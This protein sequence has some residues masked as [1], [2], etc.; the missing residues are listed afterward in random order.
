MPHFKYHGDPN[1]RTHKLLAS[2]I[3]SGGN[4]GPSGLLSSKGAFKGYVL[5]AGG[6]LGREG[7]G[8]TYKAQEC[9]GL[10]LVR[11]IYFLTLPGHLNFTPMPLKI[12]PKYLC[13]LQECPSHSSMK[14]IN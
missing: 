14:G 5:K 11:K 9:A 6:S 1:H 2:Y 10:S 13:K 7:K 12:S 4:V 8:Q 3:A